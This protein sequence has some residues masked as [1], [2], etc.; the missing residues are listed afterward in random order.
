MNIPT[1]ATLGSDCC[2]YVGL[3]CANQK[4]SSV[5]SVTNQA[6]PLTKGNNQR[7]FIG[8]Y[9]SIRAAPMAAW[10]IQRTVQ[11][12]T[13]LTDGVQSIAANNQVTKSDFIPE[14]LG[15]HPR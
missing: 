15:P 8:M 10:L 11:R 6:V 12:I 5:K 7:S 9:F 14:H 3:P 4:L 2:G 13:K 1:H